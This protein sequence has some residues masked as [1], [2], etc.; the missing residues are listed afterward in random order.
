MR[1]STIGIFG[2]GALGQ[3]TAK[4]AKGFGMKVLFAITHHQRRMG[5]NSPI[6][7]EVLKDQILF[8]CTVLS[9]TPLEDLLEWSNLKL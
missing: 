9:Q 8:H 7:E 2:E 3:G 4:I 6:A 5:W 1:N